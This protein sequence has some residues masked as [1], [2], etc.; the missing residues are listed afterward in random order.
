MQEFYLYYNNMKYSE[1]IYI[2]LDEIK[3]NSD[4]SFIT[5]DHV[6]FI[7][8]KMR[9]LLLKQRYSDVKKSIPESNYQTICLQLE[10]VDNISGTLCSSTILRS[11]EKI[12]YLMTISEPK[13]YPVDYYQ[14]DITYVNRDRFKYVGYNKYLSNIIYASIDPNNYLYLKSNNPQ[15]LY[16]KE[17]K[18]T[19]IFED[20][21]AASELECS[22]NED[23]CD[24]FDKEFPIEEALVPDLIKLVVQEL[25]GM[26]YKPL[27]TK[28]NSADD[29]QGLAVNTK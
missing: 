5:E 28:N 9:N 12:P 22:N 8:N 27:D 11:V 16:L 29:L 18:L 10:E 15:Y 21:K 13:V 23:S 17:I 1:I 14:G 24:I 4:D 2:C 3:A 26:N 6:L 19:G 20:T 7:A 25:I